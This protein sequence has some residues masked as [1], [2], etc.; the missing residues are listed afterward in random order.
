M[1]ADVQFDPSSDPTGATLESGHAVQLDRTAVPAPNVLA[2]QFAHSP[3]S[4]NFPALQLTIGTVQSLSS[5]DP[6]GATLESGQGVQLVRTAVPA[7]NVLGGHAGQDVPE[8]NFP[9][10]HGVASQVMGVR[11]PV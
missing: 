2:G 5:S 4:E 11:F 7:P 9:G 3:F 8:L 10:P 1:G 6:A